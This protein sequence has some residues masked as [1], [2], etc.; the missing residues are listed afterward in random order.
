MADLSDHP[1]QHSHQASYDIEWSR[2]YCDFTNSASVP[3]MQQDILYDGATDSPAGET[4]DGSEFAYQQLQEQQQQQLDW[5]MSLADLA[6]NT[7]RYSAI[8]ELCKKSD[9]IPDLACLLW[10]TPG[11]LAML[12]METVRLYPDIHPPHL[13]SQGVHLL[14]SVAAL[15]QRLVI[16]RRTRQPF[17][18]SGTLRLFFPFLGVVGKTRD[19][20]HLRICTLSLILTVCQRQEPQQLL[21]HLQPTRGD[22]LRLVTFCLGECISEVGRSMALKILMSFL[23]CDDVLNYLCHSYDRFRELLW[24]MGR[25]VIRLERKF[26]SDFSDQSKRV[27]KYVITTFIR[28]CDHDLGREALMH[29]IPV[30]LFDGRF[31]SI[32]ANDEQVERWLQQLHAR[33]YGYPAA[34]ICVRNKLS[35]SPCGDSNNNSTSGPENANTSGTTVSSWCQQTAAPGPLTLEQPPQQQLT[36]PAAPLP[37]GVESSPDPLFLLTAGAGRFR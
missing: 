27:F 16:D 11:V 25:L 35:L 21:Q 32:F 5:A 23:G 34:S 10:C 30:E 14:C 28:I 12:V 9:I 17:L 31:C 22:L 15:Q 13:D 24:A 20:E 4:F 3:L 8:I 36:Q 2:G 33:I 29:C 6:D 1:M 19:T 7:R 26:L 37:P 18:E